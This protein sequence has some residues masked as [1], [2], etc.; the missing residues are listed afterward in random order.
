M[1][2]CFVTTWTIAHQKLSVG[3]PRQ[4]YWSGLPFPSPGIIPAQ[5]S[6]LHLQ[7]WQ[8]SSLPLC[9]EKPQRKRKPQGKKPWSNYYAF[10]FLNWDSYSHMFWFNI[11]ELLQQSTSFYIFRKPQAT[12]CNQLGQLWN[13][14]QSSCLKEDWIENSCAEVSFRECFQQWPIRE[15]GKQDRKAEEAKQGRDFRQSYPEA[16]F[17]F[18][19]CRTQNYKLCPRI[20]PNSQQSC[21]TLVLM[22][23]GSVV[24]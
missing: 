19:L 11:W 10:C 6:N 12:F 18:T 5:G 14:L 7:H 13:S 2:D 4:E 21:C 16:N 20:C 22:G 9:Q 23:Y 24:G 1:S 15:W 8:A 17:S 3:F